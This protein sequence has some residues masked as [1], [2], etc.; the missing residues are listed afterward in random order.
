MPQNHPDVVIVRRQEGAVTCIRDREFEM[1]WVSRAVG[2]LATLEIHDTE[3]GSYG[4]GEGGGIYIVGFIIIFSET[5]SA[6][7]SETPRAAP[8]L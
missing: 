1:N 3:V 7:F 8:F 6:Y 4:N 2:S 5:P